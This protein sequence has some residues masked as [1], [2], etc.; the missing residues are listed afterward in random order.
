MAASDTRAR[1]LERG[2]LDVAEAAALAGRVEDVFEAVVVD[3]SRT[4]GKVQLREPV[5]L[6]SVVGPV[7][8]GERLRVRLTGADPASGVVTFERAVSGR[9]GTR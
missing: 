8:L 1:R 6:A 5:V 2:C 3:V 7:T 4:G 9:A